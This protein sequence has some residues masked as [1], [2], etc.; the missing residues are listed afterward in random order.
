V[1]AFI[2]LCSR[3][4][5]LFAATKYFTFKIAPFY[6]L[7]YQYFQD[8]VIGSA[9]KAAWIAYR[10]RAKTSTLARTSIVRIDLV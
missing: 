2:L 7:M 10:D 3:S 9:K 8:L 6:E 4:F 5:F 1:F